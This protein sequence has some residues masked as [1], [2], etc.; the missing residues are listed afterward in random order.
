MEKGDSSCGWP[1]PKLGSHTL[2]DISGG[3]GKASAA[4][5]SE[6]LHPG[7]ELYPRGGSPLLPQ[8]PEPELSSGPGFL[9]RLLTE[10]SQAC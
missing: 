5:G 6:E 3:G 7:G 10:Y 8:A 2:T 1:V 9:S 4:G